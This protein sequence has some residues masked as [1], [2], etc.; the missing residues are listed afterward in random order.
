MMWSD[1]LPNSLPGCELYY[2]RLLYMACI[3]FHQECNIL[4]Y[5]IYNYR[6]QCYINWDTNL[7][8][9]MYAVRDYKYTCSYV[10]DVG[11]LGYHTTN[12]DVASK[13]IAGGTEF[14]EQLTGFEVEAVPDLDSFGEFLLNI[15]WDRPEGTTLLLQ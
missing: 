1:P 15:S 12:I 13:W 3:S 10:C 7:K 8:D 5:Y 6:E 14:P 11:C 4:G 2:I 9:C